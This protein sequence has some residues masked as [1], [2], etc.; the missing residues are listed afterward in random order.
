MIS[1]QKVYDALYE[2]FAHHKLYLSRRFD[3][4]IEPFDGEFPVVFNV[5]TFEPEGET[6]DVTKFQISK[7]PED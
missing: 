4:R 7:L 6:I 3:F 5:E 2:A 1:D